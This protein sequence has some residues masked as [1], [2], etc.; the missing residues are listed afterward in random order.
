M[1]LHCVNVSHWMMLWGAVLFAFTALTAITVLLG[2]RVRELER[3]KLTQRLSPQP[4]D[5]PTSNEGR[6]EF[7]LD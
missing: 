1:D 4:Q 3:T 6:Q 2:F 5:L 7:G